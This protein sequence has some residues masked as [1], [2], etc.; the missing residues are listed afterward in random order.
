MNTRTS[1]QSKT[2]FPRSIGNP[3]RSALE[4]AGYTKLK[5]LTKVTEKELGKLHG[6]G[7]KALGILREELK[8]K[9]MSFAAERKPKLK[10]SETVSA[11]DEFMKKLKHPLKAEVQMLR[12][13]IK[14]EDK[15]ITEQIKWN[16]PT[17][18]YNGEYLVTFNLW[19]KK[20]IHLVFHNPMI[21]K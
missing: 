6:I 4:H 1:E 19:E 20:K 12:D 11:V 10:K 14:K 13:I 5:Q 7:P 15:N 2:D 3:A 18:S 9:G 21:S 16:A 17:F 8:A